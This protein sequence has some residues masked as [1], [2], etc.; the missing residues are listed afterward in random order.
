MIIQTG[1]V[2]FE[3]SASVNVARIVIGGFAF[4]KDTTDG[5]KDLGRWFLDNFQEDFKN[6]G[7]ELVK[8]EER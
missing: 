7:L 1:R 6:M 5:W 2:T 3:S 8:L 4:D